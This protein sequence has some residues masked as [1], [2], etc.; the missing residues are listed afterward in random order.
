MDIDDYFARP[1]SRG[2]KH[3]SSRLQPRLSRA[4]EHERQF[5]DFK[6]LNCGL[7]VSAEPALSGVNNRNHCPYCL[8]SKHVDLRQPGDRLAACK[9]KMRAVG[10]AFKRQ[11]KKYASAQPGELMVAHQCAGCGALSINRI[12]ADDSP[13]VL[14][15]I[16]EG[17]HAFA[18]PAGIDL[19]GPGAREALRE[20]LVEFA[21]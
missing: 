16:Y 2:A 15:D 9:G 14:W 5:G 11:H 8:W 17:S 12:A 20:R 13:A 6:C 19:L 3:K 21:Q 10:L 1:A 4:I 18:A 7:H